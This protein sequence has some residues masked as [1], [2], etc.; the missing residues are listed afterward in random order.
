MDSGL[1]KQNFRVLKGELLSMISEM[2]GAEFYWLG[3]RFWLLAGGVNNLFQ[4][5]YAKIKELCLESA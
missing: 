5:F 4:V 1:P 3:D 2:R